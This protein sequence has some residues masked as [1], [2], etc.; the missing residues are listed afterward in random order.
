[1][2]E[3]ALEYYTDSF[4]GLIDELEHDLREYE[5]LTGGHLDGL[6]CKTLSDLPNLLVKVRLAQGL[7]QKELG[8]QLNISAQ[9]VQRYE[10]NG[11]DAISFSRL[12]D[13]C[14]KLGINPAFQRITILAKSPTFLLPEDVMECAV[15]KME[16]CTQF[17]GL[18]ICNS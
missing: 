3:A 13:V 15:S 6:S 7:S 2:D 18:F 1:M 16:T 14:E 12:Q 10:A 17:E 11:Y 8:D 5:Y 4:D 9:Q